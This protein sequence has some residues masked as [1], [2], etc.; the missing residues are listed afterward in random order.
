MKQ[1]PNRQLIDPLSP[2]TPVFINRF[3]WHMALANSVALQKAGITAETPDPPGG[4]IERDPVDRRTDRNPE[5]RSD[6][7]GD[8]GDSASH[9]G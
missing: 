3:D 6:G 2:D 1:L 9:A 4:E 5:R 7:S 8:Q